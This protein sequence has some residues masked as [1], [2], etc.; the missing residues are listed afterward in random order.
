MTYTLGWHISACHCDSS[1]NI[2]WYISY[3]GTPGNLQQFGPT[4]LTGTGN[5][6]RTAQVTFPSGK[7]S[8]RALLQWVWQGNEGGGNEFYYGCADIRVAGSD[9]QQILCDS[10]LVK[11][12]SASTMGASALLVLVAII[13]ALLF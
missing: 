9:S 6:D 2:K 12:D 3:D 13:A 4:T 5:G 7:A 11:C 8:N 1:T 10:N